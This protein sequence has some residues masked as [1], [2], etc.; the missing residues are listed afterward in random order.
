MENVVAQRSAKHEGKGLSNGARAGNSRHFGIEKTHQT[1]C[2]PLSF[3]G[4]ESALTTT[5][6]Q[7]LLSYITDRALRDAHSPEPIVH[8]SRQCWPRERP[9][10]LALSRR[11]HSKP[12]EARRLESITT[13]RMDSG[14]AATRRPGMTVER[15]CVELAERISV[16]VTRHRSR[17]DG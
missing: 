17:R 8:L 11:R 1:A 13:A 7:F 16:A 10:A 5:H 15:S 4:S 3:S 9:R 2:R 12:S 6:N 14:P